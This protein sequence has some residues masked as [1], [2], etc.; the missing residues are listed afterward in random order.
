MEVDS[1]YLADAFFKM[2]R[3]V[4]GL[5]ITREFFETGVVESI[6]FQDE[7]NS[8]VR[9]AFPVGSSRG[10]AYVAGEKV[11]DFSQQSGDDVARLATSL[12]RGGH[13][14]DQYL[15]R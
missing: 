3:R 1:E 14:A 7:A 8:E 5:G 15:S 9:L 12:R 10:Q 2:E 13:G 11:G 6:V 4:E